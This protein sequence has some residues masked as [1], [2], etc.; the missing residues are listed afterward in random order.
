MID[1][2]RA[3]NVG[4]RTASATAL[5]FEP[6]Q[7]DLVP[8]PQAGRHFVAVLVS[9]AGIFTINPLANLQSS[10]SGIFLVPSGEN[11]ESLQDA[12]GSLSL[13]AR[14]V[15]LACEWYVE[16]LGAVWAFHVVVQAPPIVIVPAGW[17]F[18]FIASPNG[19]TAQ[20]G[21]GAGSKVVLAAALV[22]EA[23]QV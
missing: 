12:I 20:P 23:N 2:I 3:S 11:A 22:D 1:P 14:G 21:P 16:Q 7:V 19:G 13:N 6:L 8:A 9:A 4:I 5:A 15:R 18:R 17:T 10:A